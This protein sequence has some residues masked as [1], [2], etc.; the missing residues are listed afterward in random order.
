MGRSRMTIRDSVRR[1]NARLANIVPPPREA[2]CPPRPADGQCQCCPKNVG[3]PFNLVMHHSHETGEFVAWV[4][5]G[6]NVRLSDRYMDELGQRKRK[7]G[8]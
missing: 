7:S 6:C 1:Y 8:S 2:D 4:C 3:D 5:R